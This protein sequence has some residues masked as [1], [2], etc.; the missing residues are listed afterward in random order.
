MHTSSAAAKF[1]NIVVG[2]GL[3]QTLKGSSPVYTSMGQNILPSPYFPSFTDEEWLMIF[4]RNSIFEGYYVDC[5]FHS[6]RKAFA[7]R[8]S[9]PHSHLTVSFDQGQYGVVR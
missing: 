4:L 5:S 3:L 8:S 1:F 9:S 7:A 2:M 6:Q